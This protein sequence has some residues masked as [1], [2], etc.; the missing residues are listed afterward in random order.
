MFYKSLRNLLFTFLSLLIF[1]SCEKKEILIGFSGQ[2]TGINSDLGIHGRNGVT[3]AIEEINTS[4]GI[5]GKKIKLLI[6]DDE[7]KPEKAVQSDRELIDE[8]VT[9]II[10]HMT[11]SQTMAALPE[12]EKS[13]IVLLSP[14]TSTPLLSGKKDMFFRVQGSSEQSAYALGKFASSNFEMSSFLVLKTDDNKNFTEPYHNNFLKGFKEKKI[15]INQLVLPAE[16]EKIKN[17]ISLAFD[18]IDYEGILII[19]SARRTAL[20]IQYLYSMDKKPNIFI[21]SWGATE[22]L[23][24]HGGKAVENAYLAKTGFTDVKTKDY[25]QFIEKFTNRFGKTPSFSAEQGY[26][27]VKILA[28]ALKQT[29]GK[30][31]GLDTALINIKKFKTFQGDLTIDE[32]GDAILPVS[33]LKIENAKFKK[34]LEIKPKGNI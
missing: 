25:V 2:L 15:I 16:T 23:I 29:N 8:G 21:S 31:E 6:K 19:T 9:A 18:E 24:R 14:T 34:I 10:G 20:I 28:H 26:I 32:F 27:A 33:I 13:D 11:S 4:G 17:A 5:R 7:G 12:I 30:K 1:C 3:L 22:A